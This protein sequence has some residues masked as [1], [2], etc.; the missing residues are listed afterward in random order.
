[1]GKIDGRNDSQLIFY[2]QLIPSSTLV[3]YVNADHWAIAVPIAR[4]HSFVASAFTTQN[5]YPREALFE[6]ILPYV[7]EDLESAPQTSRNALE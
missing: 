2:N 7:E 3:A 4:T 6:A 1:M 5:E